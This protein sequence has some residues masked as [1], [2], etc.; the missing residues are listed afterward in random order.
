MLTNQLVIDFYKFAEMT[1]VQTPAQ[2]V[3]ARTRILVEAGSLNMTVAE[4]G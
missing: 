3:V 1:G 4:L 2:P